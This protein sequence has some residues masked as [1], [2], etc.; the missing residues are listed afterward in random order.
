[1]TESTR[2]APGWL[3]PVG[4]GVVVIVL[5]TIAL[6]RGPVDLDPDSPEGTVQQ[7]LL[8]IN[9]DRWDD[10]V[11]VIHPDWLG[12]CE[13]DDVA[14]FAPEDFTAELGAPGGGFPG[15]MVEEE[16]EVIGGEDPTEPL[17][18]GE[19]TVEVTIIHNDGGGLGST[20]TEPAFFELADD[21]EFWWIVNDPWPHFIWN[22]REG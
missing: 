17:P 4:L 15:R 19:A 9:E 18:Q 21:D 12:A 13:G 3:L 1:M 11:E 20:W 16:F 14:P 2:K 5:V 10:A 6:T 22:C 8:A 7:Y